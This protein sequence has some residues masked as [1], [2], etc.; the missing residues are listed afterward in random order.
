MGGVDRSL[1]ARYYEIWMLRLAGLLPA[2]WQCPLCGEAI[3][4][5]AALLE[6][7]AA[8]VCPSCA[9]Q[10]SAHEAS[11]VSGAVLEM[12]RRSARENLP[13]MAQTPPSAACLDGV[14]RLCAKVR[15][16]FLQGE[17]RSYR[18]MRQTLA[19]IA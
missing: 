9:S 1:A 13:T 16:H 2:P 14:E 15:R 8:I 12:L 7:E 17:L 5:R 18:M 10:T 3:E 6:S 4:N 19:G 11:R